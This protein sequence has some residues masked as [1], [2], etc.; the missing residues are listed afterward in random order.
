MKAL[1]FAACLSVLLAGSCLFAQQ[2][3]TYPNYQQLHCSA[4]GCDQYV[5]IQVCSGPYG[6]PNQC[7]NLGTTTPCCKETLPNYG[8]GSA[9]SSQPGNLCSAAPAAKVRN[10]IN[11]RY[12]KRARTKA[13]S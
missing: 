13:A 11:P 7:V 1:A 4:A 10:P 3:C 2:R 5:A 12:K 6:N 9:C 8:D